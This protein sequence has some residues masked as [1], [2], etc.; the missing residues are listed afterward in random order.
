MADKHPGSETSPEATAVSD[1]PRL[2]ER[3]E[4]RPLT[5]QPC[6]PG[7]PGGHDAL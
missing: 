2:C 1:E 3:E 6:V 7:S 4:R 5:Q